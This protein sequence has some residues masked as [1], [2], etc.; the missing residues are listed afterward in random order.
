MRP[1]SAPSRAALLPPLVVPALAVCFLCQAGGAA[2]AAELRA[3]GHQEFLDRVEKTDPRLQA[4]A[5]RIEAARAEVAGARVLANPSLAYDREEVFLSGKG[6][7]DNFLRLSVPFEVSGRRAMRIQAAEVGVR[8]AESDAKLERFL[9]TVEALDFYGRAAFAREWAESLRQGRDGLARL[10]A[11]ARARAQAGEASG[12]DLGRLEIELGSHESLVADEEKVLAVARRSLAYLVGDASALLDVAEP[13]SIP[14]TPPAC[15]TLTRTA[16][17]SRGDYQA[18]RQRSE[19]AE[20]ELDA[21]RR[22]WVPG[23]SLTGGL[24]TSAVSDQTAVGYVAGLAVSLP[25]LDHGQAE[26][27]RAEARKQEAQAHLRILERQVMASVMNACDALTR[28]IED[29]ARFEAQLPRL[30]ELLRRAEA[31]YQEGERPVF[32]LLDA[33]RTAREVRLRSLE[34][35]RE[36][37]RSE[38]ELWR[39]LGRRP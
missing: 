13:V 28:S 34:L 5:A 36:A 12:Y 27:A 22:G 19:Q 20:L 35:K 14:P 18:A 26:R 31:A 25:V 11:G 39:A 21:G 15:E 3:I 37:R 24:R 32:E 10:V 1:F 30:G 6:A 7:A 29:A 9:L 23:L 4:L 38:L 16:L 2:R 33:F 8:A 17:D